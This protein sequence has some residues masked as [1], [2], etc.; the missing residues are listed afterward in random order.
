V[1]ELKEAFRKEF[2]FEINGDVS[3]SFCE[4]ADREN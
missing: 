1:F 3:Y 2:I 4:V